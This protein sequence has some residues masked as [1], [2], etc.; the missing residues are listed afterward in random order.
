VLLD[1][2]IHPAFPFGAIEVFPPESICH[3]PHQGPDGRKLCL[4]PDWRAPVDESRL[5]VYV[6]W[7]REWLEDA[8]KDVLLA[9]GDAYELPPFI[10]LEVGREVLFQEDNE[11]FQ[12]WRS[13][14][15]RHGLFTFA[16]YSG[17]KRSYVTGFSTR[18]GGLTLKW[19]SLVRPENPRV[20]IWLRCSRELVVERRRAPATWAE[21]TSILDREGISLRETLLAYRTS[22]SYEAKRVLLLLGFPIPT[23]VGGENTEIHWQPVLLPDWSEAKGF[24]PGKHRA[25]VEY[26]FTNGVMSPS[27]QVPW[28]GS[29]NVSPNRLFARGGLPKEFQETSVSL[30]GC[31]SLGSAIASLITR[32][33]LRKIA[34]FDGDN[35]SAGNL[36]RHECDIS[37]LGE[38]KARRLGFR[39]CLISPH[40]EFTACSSSLPFL[41]DRAPECEELTSTDLWIDCSSCERIHLYLDKLARSRGKVVVHTYVT[42]GAKYICACSGGEKR[43]SEEIHNLV[44]EGRGTNTIPDDFFEQPKAE[45]LL[46]EGAGCWHPTFP[47]AWYS[48]VLLASGLVGYLS[49]LFPQDWRTP[50]AFVMQNPWPHGEAE[51]IT[52]PVIWSQRFP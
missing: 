38:P 23:T 52:K 46:L 35:I 19:G 48:I 44:L 32:G 2:F 27:K 41:S 17:H 15:E 24:R 6:A 39:L 11:S 42:F 51:T 10:E 34:L 28:A 37:D 50:W 29:T 30:V 4:K 18:Q 16:D 20:G 45:D 43:T 8:A 1:V 25:L 47:A 49:R 31:G 3:Y 36:S 14:P 21:L 26:A 5:T 7:A 13:N 9:P 12:W 33:G 22:V 40:L